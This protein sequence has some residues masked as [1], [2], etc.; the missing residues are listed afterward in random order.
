M[1]ASICTLHLNK[2]YKTLF[3]LLS[4]SGKGYNLKRK[5][6]APK[7]STLFSLREIPFHKGIHLICRKTHRKFQGR[8]NIDIFFF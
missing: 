5:D 2:V 8:Q 7:G 1:L 6:F 4:S 3:F